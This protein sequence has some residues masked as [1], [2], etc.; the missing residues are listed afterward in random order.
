VTAEE[1]IRNLRLEPHPEGGFYRETFRDQALLPSGRNACTAIYF[2]L[3]AGERSRWHR[4]DASEIWLWHA[5]GPLELSVAA[6][7]TPPTMVLLG[8]DLAGGQVPQAVVP[9]DAWQQAAPAAGTWSLVSCVVAPGFTFEGFEL[10]LKDF[11]PGL[12]SA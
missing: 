3:P 9:K 5:G 6:N 2:L 8:P 4:V 7:G 10:A 11:D 1:V 12:P